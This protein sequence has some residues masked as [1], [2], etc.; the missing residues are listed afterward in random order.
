[1]KQ[2]EQI[3]V[4][5]C[6]LD[7]ASAQLTKGREKRKRRSL[8]KAK[9]PEP[10]SSIL[11]IRISPQ[12]YQLRIECMGCSRVAYSIDGLACGQGFGKMSILG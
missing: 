11:T 9:V 6:M 1:M 2:A 12:E 10:S 5:S 3:E 4:R 8:T 7:V